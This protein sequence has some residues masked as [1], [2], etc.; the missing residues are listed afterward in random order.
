MILKMQRDENRG[1]GAP[2]PGRFPTASRWASPFP[3]GSLR[4]CGSFTLIELLVVMAVIAVLAALLLPALASA[5]STGRSVQCKNN[6]RQLGIAM[7]L[8]TADND[9]VLPYAWTSTSSCTGSVDCPYG[10]TTFAALIYPYVNNINVYICPGSQV[11][12]PQALPY[13]ATNASGAVGLCLFNSFYREN[14][15]YFYFGYGAG[16]NSSPNFVGPGPAPGLTRLSKISVNRVS[17]LIWI[18]DSLIVSRP[19]GPTPKVANLNFWKNL[20]GDGNRMN[21]NNYSPYYYMP[22]IGF[23]HPNLSANFTFLDG[24]VQSVAGSTVL[25]D[26]N[27]AAWNPN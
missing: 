10:G 13:T 16:N 22:N 2:I 19:Y 11:V 24:H 26:T 21:Q 8:Y 9:D 23:F 7:R 3:G 15:Y 20:T 12:W 6:Q 14:P 1:P 5:R 18:H 25:T 4:W 17:N 27:D